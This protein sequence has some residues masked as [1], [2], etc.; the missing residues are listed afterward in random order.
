M[1]SCPADKS[2][3]LIE[4]IEVIKFIKTQWNIG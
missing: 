4:R 3:E 1:E 2:I